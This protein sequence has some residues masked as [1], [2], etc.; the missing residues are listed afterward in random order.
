MDEQ[1]RY[2]RYV[3]RQ[4]FKG[5]AARSLENWRKESNR[6]SNAREFGN[7]FRD[8]MSQILGRT[9]D[10]GWKIEVARTTDK[11]LRYIDN[12]QVVAKQGTEFKAGKLGREALRQ[13]SKDEYLLDRGWEI[14]WFIGPKSSMTKEFADKVRELQD[15][16]PEQFRLA[17]VSPEQFKQAIELGKELAKQRDAERVREAR[18]QEL[19]KA[20]E[21]R[22][23]LE[24]KRVALAKALEEQAREVNRAWDHGE[25]VKVEQVRESHVEMSKSLEQIRDAERAQQHAVLVKAGIPAERLPAVEAAL[26]QGR[27]NQRRETVQGIGV[28]ATVI[29]RR[30]T[31]AAA[32]RAAA[33]QAQQRARDREAD[34]A[35]QRELDRARDARIAELAAQGRLSEQQR[36]L[37]LGQAHHPQAAV[38]QP[39]GTAPS[40]ERGG[41]RG[42]E[43]RG[44]SRDR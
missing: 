4:W 33:E 30:D 40:V 10:R 36:L 1:E 38:R 41:T 42:P 22:K 31:A 34:R 26:E 19:G 13:L 17:R 9:E 6:R 37:H 12:A 8:G 21:A 3:I 5:K 44:I 2:Q 25:A 11:G 35:A 23:A 32:E 24:A 15:R 29:E 28:L 43:S 27:E 18:Q 14:D 20:L 7:I 39:P 16:Y